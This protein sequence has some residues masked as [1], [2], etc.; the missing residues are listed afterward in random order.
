MS[1]KL[2]FFWAFLLLCSYANAQKEGNVWHFGLG[3]AIDFNSGAPTLLPVS[4]IFTF[5]GSASY[6]D[7][8]GKLLFYTN[9]G[10]RIPAQSGQSGGAIWD[11]NGTVMYDMMGLTG[12][13]FSAVQSAVF[14]P[15]PNS[16]EKY[17]LFTMEE[18]EFD[19]GGAVPGQPKGRGL[20][21]FEIDQTL[22]GGLGGVSNYVESIYVPT[23]EAL[24]A[25]RHSNA[26]DYWVIVHDSLSM[27]ARCYPVTAAGIGTPVVNS[28]GVECFGGIECSPDGKHLTINTNTGVV[29]FD[30]DASTGLISNV[31]TSI[32]RSGEVEF[33]PNSKR[34]FLIEGRDVYGYELGV[35]DIGNSEFF[36]GSQAAVAN[37]QTL[38]YSTRLQLGPDGRIYFAANYTGEKTYLSAI[39]CPNGKATVSS[40]ILALHDAEYGF[41]GMPNF[42]DHIFAKEDELIP[43]S[44]GEDQAICPGIPLTLSANVPNLQYKWSTGATTAS[45]QVNQ[46]GT[47]FVSVTDGCRMGFDTI[48]LSE[49]SVNVNAGPDQSICAGQIVQLN[50]TAPPGA[51]LVWT[52]AVPLSDPMIEDPTST[53]SS[54]T[55]YT[56]T[57]TLG[58]CSV[59]DTVQ[60][61]VAPTIPTAAVA[62]TDT[63]IDQGDQV[64]LLATGGTTYAWSPSTGL[65][66]TTCPSPVANPKDST[67]YELIVGSAGFC[68]DTL[69]VTVRVVPPDCSVQIPNVF[70]PNDG[71][72]TNS[73][74]E[75]LADYD[76]IEINIYSRWGQLVFMGNKPWDGR[77]GEAD[78]PIDVYAYLINLSICGETKRYT[79]EINLLR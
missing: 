44:L 41:F 57:A 27:G 11:R 76:Q 23:Y 5:E 61:T 69:E 65:S 15:K 13:G 6:C 64:Q 10:G 54:N 58:G 20:S 8:N 16:P 52:A 38:D 73:T 26:T 28:Y 46:A 78:A 79:G 74:F 31:N 40:N 4:N 3:Q 37:G 9:G 47:Y 43:V 34:L 75:P 48:V 12:G 1:N 70:S 32:I 63:L 56:L 51:S 60:V 50:G 35:A 29:L 72:N 49:L 2:I 36:V 22:N 68:P 71:D 19:V 66:C 42:T 59:S 62:F 17:C 25:V 24:C 21:F 55:S 18:I 14:F 30:F 7:A 77:I 67:T 39:N 53:P 33:S 45:I